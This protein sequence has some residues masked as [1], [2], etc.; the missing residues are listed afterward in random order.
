MN[1]IYTKIAIIIPSYNPNQNLVELVEKL[2]LNPWYKIV[3][4]NDGS[5]EQSLKFFN[6]I[7]KITNIHLLTHS[8]N[9][10]KGKAIKTGIKFLLK[11]S[12]PIDGLITVDSDGQHSFDDIQN[13]AL[14]SNNNLNKKNVIFGVRSFDK[15]VPLRSRF[16]NNLTNYLLYILNGISIT[17]SQTGLRFLPT[18]IFTELLKL[19]GERYEYEL[20]CLFAFKKLG[21]EILELKIKTIYLNDNAD[22]H[23]R[24]FIDSAKI[25]FVFAR[26][27]FSSL[28]SFGIDITVFSL[29]LYYLESIFIST[30][31]SRAISGVF[32]FS[33]NKKIVF[34][35]NK[36]KN[37]IRESF[38]YFI[39]WSTLLILSGLIVSIEQGSSPLI[40]IPFKI[41]VDLLLFIVSFYIQKN[42][43]FKKN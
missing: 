29:S 16:G 26:F 27:S 20:E 24:P 2:S 32:N 42:I 39:L 30:L 41:F 4:I 14:T 18:S 9:Q 40:V 1:N 22:S 31:I 33:L 17:D 25:Y 13:I 23:F 19:P 34:Q 11:E 3:V 5:S 38:G 36:S 7:K 21:Y 8:N 35:A 12:A 43:I 37:L 10:G 6:S 28:L 15:N